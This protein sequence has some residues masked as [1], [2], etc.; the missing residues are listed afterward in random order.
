MELELRKEELEGSTLSKYK[1]D[2]RG[3]RR[4]SIVG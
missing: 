4:E 1:E 2:V 3:R